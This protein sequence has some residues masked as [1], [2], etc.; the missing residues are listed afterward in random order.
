MGCVLRYESI[1]IKNSLGRIALYWVYG[2]GGGRVGQAKC[3]HLYTIVSRWLYFIK[4]HFG[5]ISYNII[6]AAS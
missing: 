4:E 2:T 3:R 1:A 6:A 5:K